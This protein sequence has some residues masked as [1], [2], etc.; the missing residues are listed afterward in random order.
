MAWYRHVRLLSLKRNRVNQCAA[1][2][3]V[4]TS[5]GCVRTI[6]IQYPV[7]QMNVVKIVRELLKNLCREFF[8]G[9]LM[10]VED[11]VHSY[12]VSNNFINYNVRKSWH[13]RLSDGFLQIRI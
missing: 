11:T 13:L 9:V 6:K 4:L 3:I 8:R 2:K 12:R 1:R 5:C 10:G 7:L